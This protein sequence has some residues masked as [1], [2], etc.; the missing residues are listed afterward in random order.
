MQT[1]QELTGSAAVLNKPDLTGRE[2]LADLSE[3]GIEVGHYAVW[4]FLD[5]NTG[6]SVK[7]ACEPATETDPTSHVG[8]RYGGHR[9]AWSAGGGSIRAK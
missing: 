6:I 9:T 4:H 8:E 3:R 5:H 2:L 7:K 1:A